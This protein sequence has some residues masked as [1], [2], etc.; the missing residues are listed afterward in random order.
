M[1]EGITIGL[2]A[3]HVRGTPREEFVPVPRA[4]PSAHR[5]GA[6]P[7]LDLAVRLLLSMTASP[8]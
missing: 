7:R 8:Q 2:D 3:M 6:D 5:A 1:G 4:Q